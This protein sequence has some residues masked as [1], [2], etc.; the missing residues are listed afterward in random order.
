V[1]CML[2]TP[3]LHPSPDMLWMRQVLTEQVGSIVA[4][5]VDA[6]QLCIA[7]GKAAWLA[8]LDIY[9]LDAGGV[10]AEPS[11]AARWSSATLPTHGPTGTLLRS[12]PAAAFWLLHPV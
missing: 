11:Q 4:R 1:A 5:L 10:R 2:C 12:S 9:I 6:T 7:A 8:Y 3:K